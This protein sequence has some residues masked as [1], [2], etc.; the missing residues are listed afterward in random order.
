MHSEIKLF[1]FICLTLFDFV[2]LWLTLL[3][4]VKLYSTLF[5]FK[6][7]CL[8]LLNFVQN[9]AAMH[10]FVDV[11]LIYTLM[12]NLILFLTNQWEW[13][14][15]PPDIG[16][17]VPGIGMPHSYISI[18]RLCT[19]NQDKVNLWYLCV[20]EFVLL[21]IVLFVVQELEMFLLLLFLFLC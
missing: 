9:W 6:Q 16:W 5:K 11:F 3:S 1:V 13:G 7:L 8:T 10:N 2:W 4:F 19:S 14:S 20:I 18:T 17:L 15:A 12:N 21:V